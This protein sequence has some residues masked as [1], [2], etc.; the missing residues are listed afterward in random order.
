MSD[1]WL[2][3]SLSSTRRMVSLGW[4]PAFSAALPALTVLI[5]AP[6][7]SWSSVTPKKPLCSLGTRGGPYGGGGVR[8]QVLTTPT[9]T[10]SPAGPAMAIQLPTGHSLVED[11]RIG[12]RPVP[13]TLS[14]ARSKPSLVTVTV[15]SRS[16]PSWVFTD[17]RPPFTSLA[18]VRT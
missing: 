17:N 2:T 12:S 3:I 13:S 16:R 1:S 15:A 6:E 4:M 10:G 11:Q 7:D 9:A 18:L 8:G 5:V 14:M